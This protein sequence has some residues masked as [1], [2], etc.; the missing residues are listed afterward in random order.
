M[1]D[2]LSGEGG[3]LAGSVTI[4]G[5]QPGRVWYIKTLTG[6]TGPGGVGAYGLLANF[7]PSPQS[8]IAP[9]DTAVAVQPDQDPTTTP[10]GTGWIINGR[11]TPFSLLDDLDILLNAIGRITIGTLTGYGE[12]LA[13]GDLSGPSRDADKGRGSSES[14]D[15]V[16]PHRRGDTPA[17]DGVFEAP[18]TPLAVGL[19]ANSK[20]A[21][22]ATAT[23]VHRHLGIPSRAEVARLQAL[24]AALASRRH[25]RQ[26]AMSP[27]PSRPQGGDPPRG[28]RS[29]AHAWAWHPE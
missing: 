3:A 18:V 22:S 17:P 12:T 15:P 23:M 7:G 19:A 9:P 26:L 10:E 4:S 21:R 29:I 16:S 5:T 2:R 20:A 11:F 25:N 27:S 14:H 8:A 24:D 13:A 1:I 6:T 28:H